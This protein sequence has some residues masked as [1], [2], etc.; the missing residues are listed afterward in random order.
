MLQ[1]FYVTYMHNASPHTHIVI[2]R[3][4][5]IISHKFMSKRAKAAASSQPQKPQVWQL[6]IKLHI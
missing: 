4:T 3:A 5:Y 2:C 1:Q 6:Q